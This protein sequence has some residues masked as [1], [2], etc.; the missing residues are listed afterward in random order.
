MIFLTIKNNL[1]MDV[2]AII[3]ALICDHIISALICD[4]IISVLMCDHSHIQGKSGYGIW[5]LKRFFPQPILGILTSRRNVDMDV[6]TINPTSK[7]V[8]RRATSILQGHRHCKEP[9]VALLEYDSFSHKIT[10]AQVRSCSHILLLVDC[11]FRIQVVPEKECFAF[12]S[13][14]EARQADFQRF[15]L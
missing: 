5:M 10:H 4:H 9:C 6:D 11:D 14:G 7:N 12:C 15:A 3:S 1:V 2:H 13:T 8:L